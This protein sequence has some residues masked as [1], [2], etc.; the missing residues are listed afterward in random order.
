MHIT[1]WLTVAAMLTVAS[2]AHAQPSRTFGGL[3]VA[4]GASAQRQQAAGRR[5]PY[6]RLF[7]EP[8]QPA[9]RVTPAHT[10]PQPVPPPTVKCGMTLVPGDP[11]VDPRIAAPKPPDSQRF[12]SRIVEPTICR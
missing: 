6:G 8:V 4:P 9:P 1:R 2:V 12:H 5:N 11:Q 3:R 10:S 7:G